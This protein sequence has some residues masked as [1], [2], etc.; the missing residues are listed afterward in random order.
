MTDRGLARA[1]GLA[2]K[3]GLDR[4]ALTDADDPAARAVRDLPPWPLGDGTLDL[5]DRQAIVV[6]LIARGLDDAAIARHLGL[7]YRAVR[8]RFES[9]CAASGVYGRAAIAVAW[10]LGPERLRWLRARGAREVA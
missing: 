10:V 6:E 3:L 5:N 7:S 1:A 4:S 2:A 8:S 9:A